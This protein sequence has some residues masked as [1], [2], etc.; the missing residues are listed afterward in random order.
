[1]TASARLRS[2]API[3]A[4]GLLALAIAGCDIKHPV[5]N[6]VRGKQLFVSKCGSCHTLSHAASTG[7]I[8]P[9]LDVAFRQDRA[10]GI[11][12][13]S[14]QGLVDYWIQYP[15]TLGVM[16]AKLLT[17]QAAQDA[18]AYVAA[19]AA[20]PGQDTGA[21]ATAV[22]AT[23]PVT[24]AQG[25]VIFTSVGGCGGC[26]ILTAA[27]TT[28]TTGPNLSQ[29]LATDCATPASQRIRGKS[30]A[31]CIQTAISNPYA[32]LPSGYAAGLM[33]SNFSKTLSKTQILALVAFISSAAK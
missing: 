26:H 22:Q 9:N 32:Y 16:P 1:M 4:A 14:I 12:A 7:S 11:K 23:V 28:G 17:G 10:D 6:L 33:P 27:G 8:G 24:P 31:Q 19:V 2:L 21:L 3:L 5:T 20:R 29:R 25:K 13:T 18:A 15:N 30:L